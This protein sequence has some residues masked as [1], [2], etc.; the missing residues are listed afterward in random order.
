MG[1]HGHAWPEAPAQPPSL[2]RDPLAPQGPSVT[3]CRTTKVASRHF[4]SGF[5]LMQSLYWNVF[6][7]RMTVSDMTVFKLNPTCTILRF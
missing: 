6:V 7:V 3:S 5:Q 4:A 1:C 2:R